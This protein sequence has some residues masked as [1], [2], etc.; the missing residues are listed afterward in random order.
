MLEKRIALP[1]LGKELSQWLYRT[2]NWLKD[3]PRKAFAGL[4]LTACGW[5]WYENNVVRK[6][7]IVSP[8]VNNHLVYE[9]KRVKAEDFDRTSADSTN[10]TQIKSAPTSASPDA[11]P[12]VPATP[13]EA[14]KQ[15]ELKQIQE[16]EAKVA[17]HSKGNAMVVKSGQLYVRE[18]H[19][20][21]RNSERNW[22]I[23]SRDQQ[24]QK[25]HY[26]YRSD[27][28]RDDD[29]ARNTYSK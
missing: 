29:Y 18:P 1:F 21:I 7:Q 5:V 23:M 6:N 17:S 22:I 8:T 27:R 24:Q 20:N 25:D 10:A 4:A 15:Y 9:V 19:W 28:S 3:N 26:W 11:A 2:S 16:A 13:A 12:S 14:Q